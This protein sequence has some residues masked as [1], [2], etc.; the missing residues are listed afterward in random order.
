[1]ELPLGDKLAKA[2][3]AV[4]TA[5]LALM[6]QI[7]ADAVTRLFL[8][9]TGI[10]SESVLIANS[11][12]Q[13]PATLSN[14]LSCVL[15]QSFGTG[16]ADWVR[17]PTELA[18]ACLSYFELNDFDLAFFAAVTFPSLFAGFTIPKLLEH[19]ANFLGHLLAANSPSISS[20]FI[21]AFFESYP[22]FLETLVETLDGHLSQIETEDV[23]QSFGFLLQSLS[24]ACRHL[25]PLHRRVLAT[26]NDLELFDAIMVSKL[27]INVCRLHFPQSPLVRFLAQKEAV[28]PIRAVFFD[29]PPALTEFA[30]VGGL[31]G[32]EIHWFDLLIS[33][34]EVQIVVRLLAATA[35][36]TAESLARESPELLR[37][38][39]PGI[40]KLF[41]SFGPCRVSNRSLFSVPESAAAV[42]QNETFA[43]T[44][45][46]LAVEVS[47][48]SIPEALDNPAWTLKLRDF[49]AV[50]LK[51]DF[52]AYAYA[53]CVEM[54]AEKFAL[55]ERLI[56]RRQVARALGGILARARRFH[57]RYGN[58]IA[59]RHAVPH[60]EFQY[61]AQ[62]MAFA[63][64]RTPLIA[65][66][67][68]IFGEFFAAEKEA[69]DP[70]VRR[71]A[72]L[73]D[74]V[75][76]AQIGVRVIGIADFVEGL[77][78]LDGDTQGLLWGIICRAEVDLFLPACALFFSRFAAAPL[79][80][81]FAQALGAQFSRIWELFE[82]RIFANDAQLK[83]HFLAYLRK[84][85]W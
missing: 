37:N 80:N 50:L 82:R 8:T 19:A 3:S 75:L 85:D 59:A 54:A 31:A 41:V 1:M 6:H 73:F 60:P 30:A 68:E 42:P 57:H 4:H 69:D 74:R 20:P 13:S 24:I 77:G 40:L 34:Y 61:R 11:T 12:C 29:A 76:R 45:K 66:F 51:P 78:G 2:E 16:A 81:R 67:C 49:D 38:C 55:F 23:P 52:R 22:L 36:A 83:Q 48:M 71:L 21:L 27:L 39:T 25:T 62:L 56:A 10:V 5:S 46:A 17:A 65:R 7:R 14:L 33:P 9:D 63:N 70:R 79:S 15:C 35:P 47:P 43:R 32:L 84:P 18:N 64:P 53:K 72:P 28:D 26:V 44:F 58:R